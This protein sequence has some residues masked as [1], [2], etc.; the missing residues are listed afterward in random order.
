VG[1]GL[2]CGVGIG[3]GIGV[4]AIVG[5]GVGAG[6]GARVGVGVGVG[7]GVGA[8]VGIGV[9]TGVDGGVGAGVGSVV[10][11]GVGEGQDRWPGHFLRLASANI[12]SSFEN[13]SA[14]CRLNPWHAM[15]AITT[16]NNRILEKYFVIRAPFEIAFHFD[17]P[18]FYEPPYTF[19]FA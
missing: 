6:V 17:T 7:A 1:S 9:G 2:G 19:E 11:S 5:T 8:G 3:V 10:G 15:F 16:N 12:S 13:C 18:M 4:G 14:D